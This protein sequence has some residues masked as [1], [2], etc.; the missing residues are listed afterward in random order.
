MAGEFGV[1]AKEMKPGQRQG[2]LLGAEFSI[3]AMPRQVKNMVTDGYPFFAGTVHLKRTVVL[4]K[5]DVVLEFQGRFQAMKV[6]V[7]GALAGSLLYGNRMDISEFAR[8]GENE[9]VLELIVSNRNLFGPHHMLLNEEPESVGP[10]SFELPGTWKDGRS[11]QYRHS[12]SFV[13]VPI[14]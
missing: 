5:T 7:N 12:Y 10:Y 1:F 8:V 6:W 13:P 3:D 11:T 4:E 14:N 9:I 2:I